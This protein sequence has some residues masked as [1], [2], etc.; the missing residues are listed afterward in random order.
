MTNLK[1]PSLC[2]VII[3]LFNEEGNLLELHDRLHSMFKKNNLSYEILFIDDGSI[4]NSLDIIRDLTKKNDAVKYISFSRNFGHE[5]ASTAG[6]DYCRGDIVLLIDADLQDPPEVI[7]KMIEK[8][9]QGY[10]VVFA[11]RNLR[12][13]ETLI[14]RFTSY[15]FYR[16]LNKLVEIKIPMDTGDFRLMDRKVVD[17]VKMCKETNRFVR[18]LVAWVGFDQADILY[19]RDARL[20]GDTK[21]SLYKLFLLS[22]DAILGFSI[23]PIHFISVF[24]IFVTFLSIFLAFIVV[25]DK[26]FFDLNVPGYALLAS[27]IFLILG[28]IIF[29][30]GIIGEYVGRIY[31]QI[32]D[33][34]LYL[35]KE[36]SG[37]ESSGTV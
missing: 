23:L 37:I 25:I 36:S 16:L 28:F 27:G 24:G 2:S 5:S 17:S 26:L 6:L 31:K 35:I 3:P 11:K 21:Y 34:P 8:W 14:K 33:R 4:D 20:S 9:Q 19:D 13:G 32:Q 12:K 15:L 1:K 18:G 10:N 30:L 29:I 7:P 22:I